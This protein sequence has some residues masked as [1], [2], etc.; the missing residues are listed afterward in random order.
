MKN[1]DEED[2]LSNNE[3]P[4]YKQLWIKYFQNPKNAANKNKYFNSAAEQLS[5][6]FLVFDQKE[7]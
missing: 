7:K 4:N 3:H 1:Q 6:K 2:I 5:L